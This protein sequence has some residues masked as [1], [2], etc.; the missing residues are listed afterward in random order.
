[1]VPPLVV[2]DIECQREAQRDLLVRLQYPGSEEAKTWT[3]S[4][5]SPVPFSLHVLSYLLGAEREKLEKLRMLKGA[6]CI[7]AF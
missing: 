7:A 5:P 6:A 4:S 1:M 2:E 3:S